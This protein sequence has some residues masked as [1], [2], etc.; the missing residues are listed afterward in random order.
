MKDLPKQGCSSRFRGYSNKFLSIPPCT[1]VVKEFIF[2]TGEMGDI[3]QVNH[4]KWI[5]DG[6]GREACKALYSPLRSVY[7]GCTFRLWEVV[8]STLPGLIMHM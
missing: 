8:F 3:L 5:I 7:F 4:Q 2:L 1:R 6:S